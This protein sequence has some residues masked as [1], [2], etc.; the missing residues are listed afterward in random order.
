MEN[1]AKYLEIYDTWININ[2]NQMENSD[3]GLISHMWKAPGL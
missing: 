2:N 3:K 1:H